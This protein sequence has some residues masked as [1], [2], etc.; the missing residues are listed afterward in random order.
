MK[1]A[2]PVRRTILL[3]LLL[4]FAVA[5]SCNPS[6]IID[7]ILNK[8]VEKSVGDMSIE[9]TGDVTYDYSGISFTVPEGYVSTYALG[10][11]VSPKEGGFSKPTFMFNDYSNDYK[12]I[13]HYDGWIDDY[14]YD[15]SRTLT[16]EEPITVAGAD[17]EIFE[18]TKEFQN[19]EKPEEN[20]NGIG[21]AIVLNDTANNRA[22]VIDGI[23]RTE[24]NDSVRPI[25]DQWVASMKF[26]P[27]K[28][29]PTSTPES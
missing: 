24:D 25:F 19:S 21:V 23:W 22:V 20:F 17:G 3:S 11:V 28:V 26:F 27:A 2:D 1:H 18:Y 6:T 29:F 12:D 10:V 16:L 13:R 5:C 14:K 9:K 7:S 4:V 15:P 8:V